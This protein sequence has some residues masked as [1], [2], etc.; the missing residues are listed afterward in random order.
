MFNHLSSTHKG[1]L[2]ALIGYTAFSFSDANVKYLSE[3]GYSIYQIIAVDTAIGAMLMLVFSPFLGGIKSL[4]DRPNAKIHGL[5]I[6]FNTAVNV[7]FVYC[8]SLMPLVTLYT[9][10][11]T[12]PFVAA[13]ISIPLYGEKIGLHRWTSII[14]GFSGVLIAFQPWKAET[15]F[16]MLL[17]ALLTTVFIALTFLM[18][19]SF[20]SA[21]VLAVGF[22]PVFGCCLLVLPLAMADF[23]P[24]VPFHLIFFT[25]SGILMSVGVICISLAF[26]TTDSAAIT[27][28]V[29]L[30]I[31][32]AILFGI[33]I[34]GDIPQSLE[35]IGAVVIILSGLYLVYRER[36]IK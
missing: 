6:L 19:R 30:E 15:D 25:L 3:L 28:I 26:K 4:K 16:I 5:R 29:Y 22:Y 1:M 31:I 9:V 14:V 18:A 23:T 20:K 17:L 2:L 36:Q 35:L 8:V 27:P 24:I 7:L 11:F 21:S 10:I 33:F 12:L 34:F 32:W 13:M